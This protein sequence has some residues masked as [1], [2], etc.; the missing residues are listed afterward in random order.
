M[1]HADVAVRVGGTDGCL[2]VGHAAPAVGYLLV[3]SFSQ[4]RCGGLPRAFDAA[5]SRL[6]DVRALVVDARPNT[7]G[8]ELIARQIAGRFVGASVAYAKHE[9]RDASGGFGP[10]QTRVLDP[11]PPR[12]TVPVAVVVGP[13]DM[14]SCEAFLLMMRAAGARL[15]GERTLGAQATRWTAK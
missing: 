8:D 7:G 11:V 13:A 6:G 3:T 4:D 5:L 2:R 14:S 15:V 12:L 10:L 9:V 1:N